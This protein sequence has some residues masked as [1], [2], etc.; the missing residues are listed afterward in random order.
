MYQLAIK[1]G[2]RYRKLKTH[3]NPIWISYESELKWNNY[4]S[5]FKT[6]SSV[7]WN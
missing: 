1:S 5:I 6:V 7:V 4:Y 3:M 2:E